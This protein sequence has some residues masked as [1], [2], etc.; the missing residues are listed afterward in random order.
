MLLMPSSVVHNPQFTFLFF[1]FLFCCLLSLLSDNGQAG[2]IS[3][4]LLCSALSM[5]LAVMGSCTLLF[6]LLP[7]NNSRA[8]EFWTLFLE[9]DEIYVKV[10]LFF[11]QNIRVPQYWV[12]EIITTKLPLVTFV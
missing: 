6:Y 12:I 8:L 9:D 10:P 2:Q 3:T 5:H 1:L 7:E 11:C 4:S